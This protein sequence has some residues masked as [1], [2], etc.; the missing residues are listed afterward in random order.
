[1]QRLRILLVDDQ[2]IAVNPIGKLLRHRGYHVLTVYGPHQ[3]LE[4]VR[5]CGPVDIL[6]SDVDM[7]GMS[8]I[9]LVGE[10]RRSSPRTACMLMTGGAVDRSTLP[11]ELR[12]FPKPFPIRAL[13]AAIEMI[14][15]QLPRSRT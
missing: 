15:A 13:Y 3:A 10:F 9:D 12:V 4:V 14:G 1:M 11:P 2:R 8:G 5:I 7:P 6:L